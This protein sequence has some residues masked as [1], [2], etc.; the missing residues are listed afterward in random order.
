MST[1]TDFLQELFTTGVIT[2]RERPQPE[3]K[4]SASTIKV[5]AQTYETYRLSIS[6]P[7]LPFET[8]IAG[9]AAEVVRLASWFLVSHQEPPEQ[10]QRLLLMPR[11]PLSPG[12]HLSVDLTFRY[13]PALLRRAKARDA[14]DV[15]TQR[16]TELLRQ[17]PFSGMLGAVDEPPLSS[18]DFG[19]DGLWLY[20]AERFVQHPR[21][22]WLPTGKG[23]ET[24]ELAWR[25]SGKNIVVL[26]TWKKTVP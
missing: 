22:E 19:H 4:L 2:H 10:V 9:A 13:L 5:L 1:L 11:R 3:A 14:N 8:E 15:L 21:Q 26:K 20:Y 12:C 18:L 23:L 7:E 16:L 24:I 25:E 17:W 6:G